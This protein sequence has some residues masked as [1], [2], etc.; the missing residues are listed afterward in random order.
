MGKQAYLY[1]IPVHSDR[2]GNH[3]E[4][5]RWVINVFF[6]FQPAILPLTA[7]KIGRP[8]KSSRTS[9]RWWCHGRRLVGSESKRG[10]MFW[11]LWRAFTK[12][13][14]LFYKDKS[15]SERYLYMEEEEKEGK[16]RWKLRSLWSG[17]GGCTHWPPMFQLRHIPTLILKR[18]LFPL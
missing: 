8:N 5:G 10:M 12:G 3:I 11:F 13:L 18:Q 14:W 7:R 16:G 2:Y 4:R 15:E 6:F 1:H 9:I 17:E